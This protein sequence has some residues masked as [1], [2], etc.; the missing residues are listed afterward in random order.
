MG[1]LLLV[2]VTRVKN[3]E[4]TLLI[5]QKTVSVSNARS[6][7]SKAD[8]RAAAVW[9]TVASTSRNTVDG[10]LKETIGLRQPCR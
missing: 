10:I 6:S 9:R 7:A 8:A 4:G 2:V 1:G 3:D 5:F